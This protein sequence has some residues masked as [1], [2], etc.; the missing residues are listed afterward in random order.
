MLVADLD[1]VEL[2]DSETAG[3]PIRVN[4]PLHSAL[5]TASTAAV[6]FEL[7]PGNALATHADSAEEVLLV[8]AGEGEAH[9]GAERGR[10]RTG[11]VAVVPA[12]APHGIRNVGHTPLRVLGLFSS[13]TVVST[14]EEPL[15]PEGERVTVAG[16]LTPILA[17]LEE[18]STLAV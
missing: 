10:L 16:A 13:S 18:P 8:L 15:G 9:I 17:R 14:F 7:E 4:F 6:L 12:M 5:G 2:M 3:G 11:Q 1:A